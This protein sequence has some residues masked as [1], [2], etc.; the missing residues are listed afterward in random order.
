MVTASKSRFEIGHILRG[1]QQIQSWPLSRSIDLYLM[2]SQHSNTALVEDGGFTLIKYTWF[3]CFK[4]WQEGREYAIFSSYWRRK[5]QCVLPKTSLL[6]VSLWGNFCVTARLFLSYLISRREAILPLASFR[7]HQR[8]VVTSRACLDEKV[9]DFSDKP[10][11]SGGLKCLFDKI[12]KQW[13][14]LLLSRYFCSQLSLKGHLYK[15]DIWF[16]SY[17]FLVG[18]PALKLSIK[19]TPL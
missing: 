18:F 19:R 7:E 6:T 9:P 10:T 1:T 12:I 14:F 3:N 8:K 4:L 5:D 17:R 2:S 13:S 16:G 11:P 15:T